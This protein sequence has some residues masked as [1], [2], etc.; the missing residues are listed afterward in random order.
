MVNECPLC[1][2]GLGEVDAELVAFR[3]SDVFVVPALK[4]RESNRGHFLVCP[5]GHETS[6]HRLGARLREE[7]MQVVSRVATVGL[8]A[9]GAFGST[10]LLNDNAPDQTLHHTHIHVIPRFN[11]DAL[12]IPNPQR[13]PAPLELRLALATKLRSALG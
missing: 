3:T 11:G 7:L 6:F 1:A 10:V 12:R 5:V 2:I 4:Q 9:F 8:G 13:D